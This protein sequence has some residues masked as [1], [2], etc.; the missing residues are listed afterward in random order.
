M[1]I[2]IAVTT[3]GLNAILEPAR[4]ARHNTRYKRNKRERTIF[5]NAHKLAIDFEVEAFILFYHPETEKYYVY[6]TEAGENWPPSW[7]CLALTQQTILHDP[8]ICFQCHGNFASTTSSDEY[9]HGSITTPPE[10]SSNEDEQQEYNLKDNEIG[11]V[12]LPTDLCTSSPL[13]DS[14][15]VLTTPS[16][17]T[18]FAPTLVVHHCAVVVHP[19]FRG[20]I[21]RT[22]LFTKHIQP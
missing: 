15:Q 16:T 5:R 18:P 1:P 12:Q 14:P 19:F 7:S 6:N 11:S 3:Q 2:P 20:P 13:R 21:S 10:S 4:R 17:T 9:L 22:S 8:V